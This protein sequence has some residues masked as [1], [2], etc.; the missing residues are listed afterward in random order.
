MRMMGVFLFGCEEFQRRHLVSH[1]V[2]Q[3]FH[4]SVVSSP[5]RL[6]CQVHVV[7]RLVSQSVVSSPCRHATIRGV[8]KVI[9]RKNVPYDVTH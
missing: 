3:S 8:M 1:P 6:S 4:Q 5:S 9:N 2:S 7:S